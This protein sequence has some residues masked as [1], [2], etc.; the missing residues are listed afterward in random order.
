M[1]G[2]I[3]RSGSCWTEGLTSKAWS[4]KHSL[5][6]ELALVSRTPETFYQI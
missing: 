4:V 3:P 1:I 6:F 2:S 5:N